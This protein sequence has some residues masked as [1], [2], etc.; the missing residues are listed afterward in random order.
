[1]N[2][3][4]IVLLAAMA[5]V[6]HISMAAT[7]YVKGE[8][9]GQG[10]TRS[11]GP[12]CFVITAAH[13]VGG[14][15][16]VD[17][18][19]SPNIHGQANIETNLA[20]DLSILRV[21]SQS[22][23]FCPT[24]QEWIIS[25]STDT[26]PN[27]VQS[28]N[29]EMTDEA[30]TTH[31][32]SVE[33]VAFDSNYIFIK[34]KNGTHLQQTMSGSPLRGDGRLAG[35]LLNV[36]TS[37]DGTEQGQVFRLSYID[38]VVSSILNPATGTVSDLSVAEL[39]RIDQNIAIARVALDNGDCKI[40]ADSLREVPKS[41]QAAI[42]TLYMARASECS[43][44]EKLS[45]P[46]DALKYYSAYNEMVPGQKVILEK[47]ATLGY[48][49]KKK[50]EIKS[51]KDVEAERTAKLRNDLTGTWIETGKTFT[52]EQIG[53]SVDFVSSLG[54]HVITGTYSNGV[55]S[56]TYK[57]VWHEDV[58]S[59]CPNLQQPSAEIRLTISADGM[60]LSG[61]VD[62]LKVDDDCVVHVKSGELSYHFR[63]R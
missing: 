44:Q 54:N 9:V 10:V 12:E 56:G 43:G 32:P 36:K 16:T 13:V 62:A 35:I 33:Q 5:S 50:A 55:F 15:P 21:T 61:S 4:R 30:G 24:P 8:S 48:L 18:V 2:L 20:G 19:T 37:S 46:E 63:R 22:S 41:G 31:T 14:Q 51:E 17:I 52:I 25:S 3:R 58:L 42:W 6:C 49:V 26:P 7:V 39:Q 40:A 38:S 11:R 23:A 27:A 1:M 59:R 29:L 60:S 57:Q 53:L 28:W 34:G 45:N 47:L